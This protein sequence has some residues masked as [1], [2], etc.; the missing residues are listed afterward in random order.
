MN[1][2]D[3][4]ITLNN[5]IHANFPHVIKGQEID[6]KNFVQI[7]YFETENFIPINNCI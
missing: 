5:P 3:T 7:K 6:S 2:N 4:E 1:Q